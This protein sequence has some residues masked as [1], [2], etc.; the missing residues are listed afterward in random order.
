[1]NHSRQIFKLILYVWFQ[2]TFGIRKISHP[3]IK[4]VICEV[5]VF[6]HLMV[7]IKVIAFGVL[8]GGEKRSFLFDRS[9]YVLFSLNYRVRA[10][11]SP[12]IRTLFFLSWWLSFIPFCLCFLFLSSVGLNFPSL[13]SA[14][15]FLTAFCFWFFFFCLLLDHV[16]DPHLA[17]LIFLVSIIFT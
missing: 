16:H 1:M 9:I 4:L 12:A 8:L 5:F 6:I 2:I 7:M 15:L 3:W 17:F 11:N 10:R 14:V 13:D